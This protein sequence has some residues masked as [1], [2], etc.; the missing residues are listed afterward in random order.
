V[1]LTEYLYGFSASPIYWK[2]IIKEVICFEIGKSFRRVEKNCFINFAK[3]KRGNKKLMARK[4]K[5]NGAK[6]PSRKKQKSKEKIQKKREK[7]S[8][9]GR[10]Q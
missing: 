2:Q 3:K 1:G 4:P 8:R 7:T 6:T 9:R 5:P 10:S